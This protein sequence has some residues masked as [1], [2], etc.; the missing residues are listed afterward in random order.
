MCTC[1]F[2]VL[3]CFGR[4]SFC[5]VKCFV[6]RVCVRVLFLGVFFAF[7][8]LKACVRVPLEAEAQA[9]SGC[10]RTSL[11]GRGFANRDLGA[12]SHSPLRRLRHGGHRT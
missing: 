8:F 10:K 9:V 7:S 6:F 4:V 5:F 3:F 11:S 2:F 1:V 12:W